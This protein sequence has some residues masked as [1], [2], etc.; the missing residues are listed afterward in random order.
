MRERTR[1]EKSLGAV[2]EIGQGLEDA[3]GLIEL[4]EAEN[5]QST[6][7]EAEAE[8][9]KVAETAAKK[10]LESLLSGEADANDCY[11]EIHAG[12]GG[13]EAQDWAL[14][15]TRMYTRWAN[16]KGY[17]V[18]YIEESPGEEAGLKSTTIRI[19]EIGRAHV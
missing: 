12:A 6:L 16:A 3:V 15:L 14:I 17:K 4:A 18:E 1:L 19:S 10:Q 7:A 11:L 13:T 8:L 2:R 9:A 5:D